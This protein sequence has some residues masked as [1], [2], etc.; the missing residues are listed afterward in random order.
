MKNDF[1]WQICPDGYEV[2]DEHGIQ[3]PD[4]NHEKT[5]EWFFHPT[6]TDQ[7]AIRPF[8]KRGSLLVRDLAGLE[9]AEDCLDFVH[10]FGLLPHPTE[11]MLLAEFLSIAN[12]MRI[13]LEIYDEAWHTNDPKIRNECHREICEH[14]NNVSWG[15][16]ESTLEHVEDRRPILRQ[17]PKDLY[18]ALWAEFG[19]YVQVEGGHQK[20]DWCEEWYIPGR[21]RKSNAKH[22]FCCREHD[23]KFR[24]ER[25]KSPR[26]EAT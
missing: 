13:M 20:C 16:V 17:K 4:L 8:E 5:A 23:E 22:S 1:T 2:R 19:V 24:Y 6:S 12:S 10:E 7:Q 14:F 25:R 11:P 3:V 26:K 18:H 15:T 21:R 9:D